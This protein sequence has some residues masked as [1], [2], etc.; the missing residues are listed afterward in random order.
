[1]MIRR[2]LRWYINEWHADT[3]DT[4][5]N[6]CERL[7]LPKA[8]KVRETVVSREQL[9]AMMKVTTP[10]MAEIIELAF[11]TAMR[12]SEILKLTALDL[13][14]EERFLRVVEG[15]EGFRD[16]PLTRR[17]VALLRAAQQRVNEPEQSL[18]RL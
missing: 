2:V 3:G 15:K 16:V 1:M 17:A 5:L 11:E 13:R 18:Y 14:L 6:P 9:A 8:R 4:L 10:R 7:T 12:R